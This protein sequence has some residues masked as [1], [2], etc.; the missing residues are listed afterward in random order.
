MFNQ[1]RDALSRFTALKYCIVRACRLFSLFHLPTIRISKTSPRTFR[2]LEFTN[3]SETRIAIDRAVN[4]SD[5]RSYTKDRK[6]R[7]KPPS[8]HHETESSGSLIN[9]VPDDS[10]SYDL[11]RGSSGKC[12]RYRER[13]KRRLM[14]AIGQRTRT[15]RFFARR[16]RVSLKRSF[17]A[18]LRR[19]RRRRLANESDRK[20]S[21]AETTCN[22]RGAPRVEATTGQ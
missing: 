11:V 6:I 9:H 18:V 3:H 12:R 21:R 17:S 15:R 10:R 5:S 14:I 4:P 1:K 20:C 22:H 8:T 16:P 19:R 13:E 7:E 2:A